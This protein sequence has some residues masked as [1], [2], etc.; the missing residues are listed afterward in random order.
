MDHYPCSTSLLPY[1]PHTSQT[2]LDGQPLRPMDFPLEALNGHGPFSE[3]PRHPYD[4]DRFT[5]AGL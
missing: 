1:E 3:N 4:S 5:Q 2:A